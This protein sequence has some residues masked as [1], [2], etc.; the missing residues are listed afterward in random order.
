MSLGKT[1]SRLRTERGM[2][3]DDLAAALGVSR[4]SVSKWET[5]RSVPELDKLV[6]LSQLFGV[7]LDELV[8]GKPSAPPGPGPE[9]APSAPPAVSFQKRAGIILLCFGCLIALV[10]T[11]FAAFST[12]LTAAL[13]LLLCG[14]LCLVCRRHVGLWCG[15]A[16]FFSLD[17]YLRFGTS[18]TWRVLFL[19]I[20]QM[21]M[22]YGMPALARAEPLF[23]LLLIVLTVIQFR[24]KPFAFTRRD[25]LLLA[26]G[27]ALFFALL[28][29]DPSGSSVL[30]LPVDLAV[31]TVLLWCMRVFFFGLDWVRLTLFTALAVC[32]AR[33][34]RGKLQKSKL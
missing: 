30:E 17:V 34:L 20:F 27:W 18:I 9:P 23:M 12:G 2:S 15:W 28:L 26:A 10:L 24:K 11:P 3:Q 21:D 8:Q 25:I 7:S 16:V 29:F 22:I 19:R 13:P 14:V 5:D 33:G 1:I 4:Q 32:L 6:K 31:I